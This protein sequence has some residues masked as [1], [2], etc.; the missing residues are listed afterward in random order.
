MARAGP[1]LFGKKSNR[2]HEKVETALKYDKDYHSDEDLHPLLGLQRKLL[3][4]Y[5]LSDPLDKT[6]ALSLEH[7]LEFLHDEIKEKTNQEDVS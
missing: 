6:N 5:V 2:I 4:Q 1:C 3:R 7:M